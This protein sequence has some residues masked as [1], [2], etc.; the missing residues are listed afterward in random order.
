MIEK[1]K[2]TNCFYPLKNGAYFIYDNDVKNEPDFVLEEER[3]N[4]KIVNGT[5]DVV[6]FFQNDGC[7]MKHNDLKKCDWLC[8]RDKEFYFIE[9]KDVKKKNR[10]I[11]RNDA[12]EKFD[13]TIPY[14][15]NLYPSIKTMKLIVIMNFRNSKITNAANKA[16]ATYFDEEYNA[17]YRET[18]ILDFN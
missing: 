14:F 18:N 3:W 15:L 4:L 12:V 10:K 6:N 2:N 17:E 7:L 5:N 16:K 13:A 8:H 11:Q 1:L 9:A